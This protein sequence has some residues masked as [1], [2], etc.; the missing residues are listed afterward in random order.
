MTI[1]RRRIRGA[2][3]MGV[4]WGAVWAVAGFALAVA[5]GFQA[6]APFPLV[7]G[8]FGFAAGVLFSACLALIDGR[9]RFDQLSLPSMAG[10]GAAGGLV[11]AAVFTTLASLGWHDVIVVAPTFALASA[12]AA[13]GSLALAR[14]AGGS[15]SG[16]MLEE[17]CG[18]E[19]AEPV[20][21]HEPNGRLQ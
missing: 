14:R 10:R 9:R 3:G 13:A 4:T 1:W 7:F 12:V 6:D 18:V 11:L 8:V 21:E 16:R 19:L 5:T 17:A 2:L 20:H 15:E